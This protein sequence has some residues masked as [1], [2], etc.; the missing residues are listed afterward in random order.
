MA[1]RAELTFCP[2]DFECEDGDIQIRDLW[3]AI[4]RWA[5]LAGSEGDR[6]C[7]AIQNYNPGAITPAAVRN[8]A[9]LKGWHHAATDR[10]SHVERRGRERRSRADGG[11]MMALRQCCR[12]SE[13]AFSMRI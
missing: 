7:E 13:S 10:G 1:L 9:D 5:D 11:E 4:S 8:A 2:L 3:G 6:G 12:T